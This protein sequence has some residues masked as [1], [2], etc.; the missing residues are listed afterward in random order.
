M[1]IFRKHPFTGAERSIKIAVT[2]KQL[3]NWSKGMLIQD[4]MPNLTSDEREFIISGLLPK[5]FD[6]IFKDDDQ[7]D[8]L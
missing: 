8:E 7:D 5:E 4:A 1:E 6:E 3:D 2:E